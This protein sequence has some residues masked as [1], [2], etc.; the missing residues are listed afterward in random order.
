ALGAVGNT[1][2]SLGISD[3][4]IKDE[5]DKIRS[6]SK[7]AVD[8][9]CDENGSDCTWMSLP[10]SG[11]PFVAG[12]ADGFRLSAQYTLPTDIWGEDQS[13]Y[14]IVDAYNQR[15]RPVGYDYEKDKPAPMQVFSTDQLEDFPF[16][17]VLSNDRIYTTLPAQGTVAQIRYKP[18]KEIL[19]SW[20]GMRV[21]H[22][23]SMAEGDGEHPLG[24]PMGSA[25]ID[26]KI[27]VADPYCKTVWRITK[28]LNVPQ[29]E[30]IR[31][32]EPAGIDSCADGPVLFATFGA[33][34][35]VAVDSKGNIYVADAGC[36]SIRLIKDMGFGFDKTANTL[37]QFL[38]FGKKRFSESTYNRIQE[39]LGTASASSPII[40]ANRYWVV[41]IAG[42]A[43][44]QPGFADGP[45]ETARFNAP[46]SIAY[47][48]DDN[49]KEFLFVA[50]TGN[51]RIR[52]IIIP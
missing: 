20:A 25:T 3:A 42:G 33:P 7:Q 1:L 50:D 26:G 2:D 30:D 6:M 38:E 8:K 16:S 43:D 51:Q 29:V 14:V 37:S 9:V 21:Q 35:D 10:W 18:E 19:N 48:K 15:I 44:G 12:T 34:M 23:C 41:T 31:G 22:R 28:N 46:T 47:V 52:R 36:H 27:F 32:E 5:Q 4:W 39:Q 45:A 40:E 17:A 49:G 11:T 13:K 24:V